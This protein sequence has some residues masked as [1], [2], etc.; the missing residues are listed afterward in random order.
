[1]KDMRFRYGLATLV[2]LAILAVLVVYAMETLTTHTSQP[3]SPV[4]TTT[5]TVTP[6]PTVKKKSCGCCA[7]R[8][9][10]LRKMIQQARQ[11]Q[12]AKQR[13]VNVGPSTSTK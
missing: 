3:Q 1:M 6:N 5:P 11:R 13:P 10:R 12:Q 7:E 4:K 2:L 9:E 8:R